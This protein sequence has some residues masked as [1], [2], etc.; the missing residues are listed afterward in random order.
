MF[1]SDILNWLFGRKKLNIF[2][3][4]IHGTYVS[5]LVQTGHHFY[6]PIKEGRPYNYDGK[7]PGYEWPDTVHEIFAN[8]IK[9][10]KYDLI[11]FHTPQ[12]VFEEQNLVLSEEQRRLPKIY[13]VH[14]PFKKDPR[15]DPEKQEMLEKFTKNVL[16]QLDAIVHITKYNFNQW[17]NIFPETKNKSHIIYH[18]IPIPNIKWSGEIPKAIS[19]VYNLPE[20]IECGP[21]LYQKVNQEV[22]ITLYGF[23]SEK[24][25]GLGPLS[26]DK[27]KIEFAKHRV[28]FNSTSASSVPMAMLEAMSVG[29]PP[30]T[31]ATTELPEII[32]NDVNGFIS[33]D[34]EFLIEKIKLLL[35]NKQ[36]AQKIGQEAKKTI[37][38]QFSIKR[39]IK[40]WEY[41]FY[42]IA[43]TS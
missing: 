24:L 14:S 28:Y 38:K 39:F 41:L 11:I 17:T 6:L 42:E 20:R 43:G 25:G 29:T 40:Q 9:D 5:T 3:W 13:I 23:N 34:S 26:N 36:F 21:E 30:I 12:Q 37:E 31:T 7:T 32:K 33:N 4:N 15:N 8:Q 16:P 22:P 2:T 35:N 1:L 10:F 19:A 18:G 27:L